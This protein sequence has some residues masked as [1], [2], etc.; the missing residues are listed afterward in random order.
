[1]WR[2]ILGIFSRGSTSFI[3]CLDFSTVKICV[4]FLQLFLCYIT[5]YWKKGV[6]VSLEMVLVDEGTFLLSCMTLEQYMQL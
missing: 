3:F 2:A 4:S 6:N 1:M 5:C